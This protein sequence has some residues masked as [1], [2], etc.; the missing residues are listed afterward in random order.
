MH[1]FLISAVSDDLIQ[2]KLCVDKGIPVVP[3][4]GPSA[5]VTALSASGLPT[6]E[7]TFG[8]IDCT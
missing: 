8:R 2:A 6:D 5:L 1:K 7:F 3:I 4:P